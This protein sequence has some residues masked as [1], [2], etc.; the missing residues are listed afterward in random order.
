MAFRKNLN[1]FHNLQFHSIKSN[2]KNPSN[3]QNGCIR[4]LRTP[5]LL[6]REF[7]FNLIIYTNNNKYYRSFDNFP[8]KRINDRKSKLTIQA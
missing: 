5:P 8:E 6:S 7:L 2:Q 4:T 3:F 1:L